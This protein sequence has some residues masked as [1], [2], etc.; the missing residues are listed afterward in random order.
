MVSGG[1]LKGVESNR[2]ARIPPASATVTAIFVPPT[3]TP[4]IR[5]VGDAMLRALAA[6]VSAVDELAAFMAFG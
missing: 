5:P 4:A 2:R 3:S 6:I 1:P